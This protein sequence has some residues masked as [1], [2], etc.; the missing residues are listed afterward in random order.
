MKIYLK[1]NLLFKKTWFFKKSPG[2]KNSDIYK[3]IEKKWWMGDDVFAD[4]K[5]FLINPGKNISRIL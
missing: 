1:I 5:P 2:K 4:Q 3:L